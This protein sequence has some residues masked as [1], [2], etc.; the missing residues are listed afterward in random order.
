MAID[1]TLFA[2][3]IPA[4][5]YAA[6]DVVP[7]VAIDGPA[8]VRSGRGDAKLKNILVGQIGASSPFWKIVVKNSDW[9]DSAESFTASVLGSTTAFDEESGAVQIGHDCKLTPNSGWQVYAVCVIGGSPTGA[10]SI[11]AL[12]DVDYP[13]VAAVTSPKNAIGFPTSIPY[14][15]SLTS[16]AVGGMVGSTWTIE[17]VDYFKAG[18]VYVLDAVEM[19]DSTNVF[20]FIAFSNAAGMGGLQRIIPINNQSGGIRQAIR[21]ASAVVKGPMDVKLKMFTATA[22]AMNIKTIHD[23]VRKA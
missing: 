19:I 10:N 17:S 4:G 20:G 22:T 2:A 16:T 6:G 9:I 11:F 5:T 21:Y 1:S 18:Y 14:E 13:Q 3:D 8:N 7:L 23:Y 12:I 15:K